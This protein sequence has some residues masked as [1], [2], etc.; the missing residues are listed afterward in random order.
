MF[1]FLLLLLF[2]RKSPPTYS[3]EKKQIRPEKK[4]LSNVFTSCRKRS[5]AVWGTTFHTSAV[6]FE[7]VFWIVVKASWDRRLFHTMADP[8]PTVRIQK[9]SGEKP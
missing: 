4:R 7:T 3:A 9:K 6:S 1:V 5:L 2:S 8:C